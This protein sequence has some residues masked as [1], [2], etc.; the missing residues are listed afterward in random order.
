[1]RTKRFLL[2]AFMTM[3]LTV[4]TLP[5]IP[6]VFAGEDTPKGSGK[7]STVF[8]Y[9]GHEV[10]K[11]FAAAIS[12]YTPV[13]KGG[14]SFTKVACSVSLGES[15]SAGEWYS[16]EPY[17]DK[18]WVRVQASGESYSYYWPHTGIIVTNA[19]TGKNC[20][21]PWSIVLDI[22]LGLLIDMLYELHEEPPSKEWRGAEITNDHWIEA[23]SRQ[24]GGIRLQTMAANFWSTFELDGPQTLEFTAG[25]DIKLSYWHPRG[26]TT[27]DIGSYSV[28][29]TTEVINVDGGVLK[30]LAQDQYG[31]SLTRGDVYIDG[32]WVGFTGSIFL[33]E[34]RT[35]SVGT[36]D[37]WEAG[38]TGYR[39]G[40]KYWVE[41]GSTENPRNVTLEEDKTVTAYFNK[42]YCPGDCNGDGVV[43]E[44]DVNIVQLAWLTKRGDPNWDSRAD[45]DCND[46][47]NIRDMQGVAQNYD[48]Y[49]LTVLA[50]D[51]YGNSLTTAEVYIDEEFVGN[52]GSTF[53]V[54]AGTRKVYVSDS[55]ESGDFR[56][57]F[58]NWKDDSTENPRT[59]WLVE[60]TTIKARYTVNLIISGW[61]SPT[62]YEIPCAWLYAGR[63][64]DD[65][66][67]TNAFDCWSYYGWSP[68]WLVLLVD[69]PITCDKI[70]FNAYWYTYYQNQIDVDVYKDGEWIHVYEGTYSS[71]VW[72]EKSFPEGKVSKARIRTYSQSFWGVTIRYFYEFD[73]WG[74]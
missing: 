62:G 44:L 72:E 74:S 39:Y 18:M 64:F 67:N 4:T 69:P 57:Y 16:W 68:Y 52:T 34:T 30:V 35:Y 32:Q 28:S 48:Y 12:I 41:D 8:T 56:Y 38:T 21:D 66:L 23:I 49:D 6:Q 2:V 73:F 20:V 58:T 70:R 33:L 43:N 47:I 27:I 25:A 37:F 19:G 31:A 59:M 53:T 5:L 46:Y 26:L 9:D 7:D 54:M 29:F 60:D 40:F 22:I 3:M 15:W 45:L 61:V 36:N 10:A 14:A 1:M 50:E 63:A 24:K 42:K 71:R 11:G 13:E 51:Q 55:W 65:D 17:V